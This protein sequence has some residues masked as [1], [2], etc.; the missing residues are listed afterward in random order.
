MHAGL[1]SR[2]GWRSPSPNRLENIL[3][4]TMTRKPC[5]LVARRADAG[6]R[7][8]ERTTDDRNSPTLV[9]PTSARSW[10]SCGGRRCASSA[11]TSPAQTQTSS[12]S[13]DR[14]AGASGTFCATNL[15]GAKDGPRWLGHRE[16]PFHPPCPW[17]RACGE[18][19]PPEVQRDRRH[20][21]QK[22]R[23]T[24][25]AVAAASELAVSKMR[26]DSSALATRYLL[27]DSEHERFH[28]VLL[29]ASSLA[30][31]TDKNTGRP[32][33]HDRLR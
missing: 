7:W 6:A 31:P 32:H 23:S 33:A 29:L 20:L 18:N 8:T 24:S 30:R 15:A 10:P 11:S 26:S 2:R 28:V 9:R 19:G 25:R 14:A 5:R 16:T 27:A 17:L 12:P 22:G 1:T 13:T 3:A 21:R 4:T